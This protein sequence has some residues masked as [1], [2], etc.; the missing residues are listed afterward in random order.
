MPGLA[1]H[2]LPAELQ[3]ALER[4]WPGCPEAQRRALLGPHQ[5]GWQPVW[6]ARL[7][8]WQPAGRWWRP[9]AARDERWRAE[10]FFAAHL[11]DARGEPD[12]PAGP[13]YAQRLFDPDQPF[14][15]TPWTQSKVV[16]RSPVPEVFSDADFWV[17]TQQLW[18]GHVESAT[19]TA[20]S[21]A[22]GMKADGA[23]RGGRRDR[24]LINA[25][26]RL[27]MEATGTYL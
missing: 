12:V 3:A 20:K 15:E 26:W 22:F 10:C 17:I 5:L 27:N 4:V 16:L 21:W 9:W 2:A 1:L 23:L 25:Q 19:F 13:T 11:S 18:G 6:P 7:W 14:F 24:W 8:A